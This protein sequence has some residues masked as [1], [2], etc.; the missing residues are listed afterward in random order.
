M[1]FVDLILNNQASGEIECIESSYPV[2]KSLGQVCILFIQ[3]S[4]PEVLRDLGEPVVYIHVER[5]RLPG[6]VLQL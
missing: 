4:I 6:L 2:K 5:L 3:G 1:L